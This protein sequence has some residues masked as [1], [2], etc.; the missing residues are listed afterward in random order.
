MAT[1]GSAPNILTILISTAKA[2]SGET[3][4]RQIANI[5]KALTDQLNKKVAALQPPVDQVSITYSQSQIA[6]LM[7]QQNTVVGLQTRFGNN[8]NILSDALSQ[9]TLMTSAVTNGDSTGYDNA[10]SAANTDLSILTPA[11]YSYLFQN[12]GIAALKN[13]GL[14]LNSAASYDLSTQG[15]QDAATADLTATQK[16]VNGIFNVTTANQTL[17]G[18]QVTALNGRISALQTAQTAAQTKN[19]AAVAKQTQ[20]LQQNMQ[21]QLHLIELRLGNSSSTA[22][23]LNA[24]LHPAS[25]VTSVFGAIAQSAI[26]TATPIASRASQTATQS[27][28]IMSL[29]A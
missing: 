2:T 17:A 6:A 5:S 3:Q 19:A 10:L 1:V 15:G 16:L 20:Q 12:D 9:I 11:G 13:N 26:T 24:A 28:A 18:S 8:A 7:K 23:M 29:F 4:Q 21:N 25:P 14:G 27:P 22:T